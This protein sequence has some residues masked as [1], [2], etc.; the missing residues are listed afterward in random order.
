MDIIIGGKYQG[1]LDYAKKKYQLTDDDIF[2]CDYN[3]P[4]IDLNKKAIYRFNYYIYALVKNNL[5]F[6]LDL[7]LFKDK[8]IICDEISSGVVPIDKIERIYRD[9]VGKVMINLVSNC[10]N[11]VRIIC[12]IE[13]KLK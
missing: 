2:V 9:S 13:E 1:K 5:E 10:D 3:N 12:G 7:S 11:L 6:D 4:V 8:I